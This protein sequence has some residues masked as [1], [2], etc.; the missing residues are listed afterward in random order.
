MRVGASAR[1]DG[2]C[3]LL[4]N[5]CHTKS[6][7]TGNAALPPMAAL[8][9]ATP[10][11]QQAQRTQHNLGERRVGG[12]RLVLL[13]VGHKG[14]AHAGAGGAQRGGRLLHRPQ[15]V[16]VRLLLLAGCG[17]GEWVSGLR[18]WHLVGCWQAHT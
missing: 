17:A 9:Q 4:A 12:G 10:H 16:V 14:G 7:S 2:K 8:L 13:A 15:R 1:H 6:G 18:A 5:E 3:L 11:T